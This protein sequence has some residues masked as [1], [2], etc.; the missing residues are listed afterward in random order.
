MTRHV[1]DL[2]GVGVQHLVEWYGLFYGRELLAGE[3]KV[4]CEV[5]F[6][7]HVPSDLLK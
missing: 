5:R 2:V 6:E 1:D 7:Q 3:I 4:Y